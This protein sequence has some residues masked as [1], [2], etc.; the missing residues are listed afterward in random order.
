MQAGG[1]VARRIPGIG[2]ERRPA[3]LSDERGTILILRVRL[4]V[5]VVCYRFGGQRRWISGGTE[6]QGIQKAVGDKRRGSQVE[7]RGVLH[8]QKR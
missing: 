7:N 8:A 2:Q 5:C 1:E 4:T 3:V 6:H